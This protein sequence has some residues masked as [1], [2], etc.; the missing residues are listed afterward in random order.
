MRSWSRNE[1]PPQNTHSHTLTETVVF[2]NVDVR[3]GSG[4]TFVDRRR[5]LGVKMSFRKTHTKQD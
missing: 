4:T 1:S 2:F 5:V 3:R